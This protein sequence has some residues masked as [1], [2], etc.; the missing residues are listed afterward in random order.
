MS[1]G[2]QFQSNGLRTREIRPFN[3]VK[4]RPEYQL[5]SRRPIAE[6]F[7]RP[8]RGAV[9]FCVN[10]GV[11][12]DLVSYTSVVAAAGAGICFWQAKWL[13]A[14]LIPAVIFCYLR[15][16]L[17]MLDGM[18]ALASGKASLR[19]EIVNDLPDRISDVI[20]FV[21][22][23]HS[24]LCHILGGY[25]VAI[26][27]LVVAYVGI[28]GPAV[29]VQREFSGLMSKPWRMVML[30]AGAWITLGLLWWGD[31]RLRYGGFTILDW[32]F[33]I[34]IAG[35]LETICIRLI[36]VLRALRAPE[37]APNDGRS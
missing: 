6:F 23:A 26:F 18:V 11:H 22:A 8:T 13:G 17:N 14:L 12:P 31:G 32:T 5:G 2:Q 4:K 16:W 29:G 37:F 3:P 35:C 25:W 30:H 7:R 9:K 19:G 28:S 1:T 33:V 15:L 10:A 34:I 21:G 27:A 24:G 20:I 36:R